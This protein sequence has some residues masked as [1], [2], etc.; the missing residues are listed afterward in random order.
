[1]TQNPST[2]STPVELTHDAVR[3]GRLTLRGGGAA[4]LR[5]WAPPSDQLRQAGF[6]VSVVVARHEMVIAGARYTVAPDDHSA[7]F[8]V[9]V[10]Q[11]WQ[12]QGLGCLLVE[13]LCRSA[14]REGVRRLVT[15]FP[16]ADVRMAK[17]MERCGFTLLVH[18][19]KLMRAERGI[20]DHPCAA[21]LPALTQSPSAKAGRLGGF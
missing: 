10:M 14:R 17:L 15:D 3:V 21:A 5:P 13:A 2:R 20:P 8:A 16:D 12:S 7:E 6:E 4:V 9:A 1:M 18:S 19:S 11:G